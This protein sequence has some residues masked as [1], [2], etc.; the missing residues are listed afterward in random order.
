MQ[1]DENP[2]EQE[3]GSEESQPEPEQQ[4]TSKQEDDSESEPEPPPPSEGETGRSQPESEPPPTSESVAG[5]G[6]PEA[7]VQPPPARP[8]PLPPT[9]EQKR[10][11]YFLGFGFGLIPLIVFLIL[12]GFAQA[13][14]GY[15]ALGYLLLAGLLGFV[16]Y[17]T[18]L[19]V[20]IVYLSN[21]Q[22]RFVG[23]G[24]LTAFLATPVIASIGCYVIISA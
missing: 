15:N 1:E 8:I 21:K 14:P 7:G 20:T 10:R 3:N 9:A 11:Q 19:I 12:V 23:Y 2:Y 6:Q 16:L 22:R 4:P 13:T 17:L 24:L 18:E 5:E